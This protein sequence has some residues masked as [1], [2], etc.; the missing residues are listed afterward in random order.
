MPRC[1][2]EKLDG[3]RMHSIIA[4]IIIIILLID[5]T[6]GI[7]VNIII[8]PINKKKNILLRIYAASL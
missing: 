1:I 6:V 7:I 8:I 2:V 3:G 4:I 5:I